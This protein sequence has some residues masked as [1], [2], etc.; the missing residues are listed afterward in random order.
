[1]VLESE[2]T[3]K[4]SKE[5]CQECDDKPKVIE[6]WYNDKLYFST[7]LHEDSDL[8]N[9]IDDVTATV[10]DMAEHDQAQNDPE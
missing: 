5:R 7:C 8:D 2:V 4:V 3:I 1:M 10:I 9:V 6:G